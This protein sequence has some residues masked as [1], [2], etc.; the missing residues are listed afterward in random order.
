[1]SGSSGRVQFGGDFRLVKNELVG[2]SSCWLE[3]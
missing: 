3:G 2:D 1:M